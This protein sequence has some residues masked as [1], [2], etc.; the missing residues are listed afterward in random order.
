MA[1][2]VVYKIYV[3]CLQLLFHTRAPFPHSPLQKDN[4]RKEKEK[5]TSVIFVLDL[6]ALRGNTIFN[7][8]VCVHLSLSLSVYLSIYTSLSLSLYI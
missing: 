5:L 3:G 4:G 7:Y 2:V 1:E 6:G 8:D